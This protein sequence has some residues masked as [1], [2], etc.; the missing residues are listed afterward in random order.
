MTMYNN[1]Y[2]GTLNSG[3]AYCGEPCGCDE[4]TELCDVFP[5]GNK[6]K[7]T[8]MTNADPHLTWDITLNMF[9]PSSPDSPAIAEG[10]AGEWHIYD[11]P[12]KHFFLNLLLPYRTFLPFNSDPYYCPYSYHF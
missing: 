4:S 7:R 6:F 1:M 9:I 11:I 12:G 5:L 10:E 2:Y 3:V 8:Q